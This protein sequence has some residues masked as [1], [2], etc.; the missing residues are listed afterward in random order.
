MFVADNVD[1]MEQASDEQ[2]QDGFKTE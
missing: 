2:Y 1:W